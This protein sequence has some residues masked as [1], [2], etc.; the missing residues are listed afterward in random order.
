MVVSADGSV[1]MPLRRSGALSPAMTRFRD[2][3]PANSGA[4]TRGCR[5]P[6]RMIFR[7][8]CAL[9]DGRMKKIVSLH[10][11]AARAH[12]SLELLADRALR[13]TGLRAI[14]HEIL[15]AV[16]RRKHWSIASL[17]RETG[18]PRSTLSRRLRA[19]QRSGWVTLDRWSRSRTSVLVTPEGLVKLDEVGPRCEE[20]ELRLLH[21]LGS[22]RRSILRALILLTAPSLGAQERVEPLVGEI[23]EL[24]E[25]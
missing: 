1:A 16:R 25:R 24:D 4:R 14:D 7:R 2:G 20:V 15:L 21:A 10:L 8:D 12:R 5:F 6:R 3:A 17:G 23:V 9:Y 19:L 13:G 22:R 18:T 11:R